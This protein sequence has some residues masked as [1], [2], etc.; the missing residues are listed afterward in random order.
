MDDDATAMDMRTNAIAWRAFE[1]F[2]KSMEPAV[3]ALDLPDQD[4]SE[5]VLQ[6]HKSRGCLME[7]LE[8]VTGIWYDGM[9]NAFH[10]KAT[11]HLLPYSSAFDQQTWW[12]S[13]MGLI[14]RT[15]VLFR[16]Q[17]LIHIH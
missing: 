10:Y 11:K 8:Y 12:A 17:L 7:E 13:Q 9:V 1:G 2:L 4:Y 5:K 6:M 3:M 15:E 16:G 14:V